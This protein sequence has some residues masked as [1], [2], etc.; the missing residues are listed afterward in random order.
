M[1][2]KTN[3]AAVVL[4]AGD[5]TQAALLGIDAAGLLAEAQLKMQE[6][7]QMLNVLITDVLTPAGDASNT[8]TLN[9]AITAIA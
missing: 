2:V 1:G 4:T 7:T 3:L 9:T 5:K 8:T 6:A